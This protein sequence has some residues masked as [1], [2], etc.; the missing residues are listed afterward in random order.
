MLVEQ[1]TNVKKLT[2]LGVERLEPLLL[3]LVLVLVRL[4]SSL[5][6]LQL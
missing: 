2:Y 3:V 6:V 4:P 5:V 1:K